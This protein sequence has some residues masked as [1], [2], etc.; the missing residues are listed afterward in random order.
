ME[1]MEES[2]DRVMVGP[3]RKSR[4]MIQKD[5][6]LTAYHEAGH[7]VVGE[8][9]EHCDPIHKVTILPRGMALG[10]TWSLPEIEKYSVSRS[11]LFDDIS[12]AL[13]GLVAEEL[14]FGERWTGASGDL[15]RVT[16]IARAMV[17]EFG[18]SDKLGTLAVGRRSRN[19]FLGRDYAE[20]RDYSEEVARLID[21]E[22]RHIV[23]TC[24][25]RATEI[26]TQNREKMDTLVAA[27]LERETLSREEFMAIMEGRPMPPAVD[28]SEPENEP[29]SADTV[30]RSAQPAPP[31]L[32]P[33]TA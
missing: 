1:D 2:L 23:D 28:R 32:E 20:D 6:E 25:Q 8:M 24:R 3:A 13:G 12:M 10:I 9:L 31:R 19:P 14:V 4:K 29:E 5:R 11:E 16:R 30:D 7:A 15:E 18:M 17:C 21:E 27:L 26:L 22:V 33:G